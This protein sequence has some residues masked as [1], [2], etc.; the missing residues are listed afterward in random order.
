MFHERKLIRKSL[1]KSA[2]RLSLVST[3]RVCFA[4]N[5]HSVAQVGSPLRCTSI[6]SRRNACV[7]QPWVPSACT[8]T[9]QA[10][11]FSGPEVAVCLISLQY[12]PEASCIIQL[13][14]QVIRP[15]VLHEKSTRFCD[16][17]RVED[18]QGSGQQK[19]TFGRRCFPLHHNSIAIVVFTLITHHRPSVLRRRSPFAVRR[20]SPTVVRRSSL[21]R[22]MFV[23]WFVRWCQRLCGRCDSDGD[24]GSEWTVTVSGQWQ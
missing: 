8:H 18:G 21:R 6:V 2:K 10:T 16:S 1:Q 11:W 17:R 3:L 7:T 14:F 24:S 9:N 23:R 13:A 4:V 5:M 20:S 15:S 19:A 12:P 22:S